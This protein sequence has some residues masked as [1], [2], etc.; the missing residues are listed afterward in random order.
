MLGFWL[1]GCFEDMESTTVF[2]LEDEFNKEL[3][4]SLDDEHLERFTKMEERIYLE[5]M[6]AFS[7][8]G[9]IFSLLIVLVIIKSKQLQSQYHYKYILHWCSLTIIYT[10]CLPIFARIISNKIPYKVIC[11]GIEIHILATVL[12][13]VLT[14][15]MTI[16]ALLSV[17]FPSASIKLRRR[18]HCVLLTLYISGI[19]LVVLVV[20][21]CIH[22]FTV[23][24]FLA[25][26][27]YGICLLTYISLMIF[28]AC[29]RRKSELLHLKPNM[30]FILAGVYMLCW[31]LKV[32]FAFMAGMAEAS[33]TQTRISVYIF[34][35]SL[36]NPAFNVIIL[37]CAD[38]LFGA[39]LIQ[40][41]KCRFGNAVEE[42][43]CIISDDAVEYDVKQE[44]LGSKSGMFSSP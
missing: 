31:F 23:A 11:I 12:N 2:S 29:K 5:L 21:I 42:E 39:A 17:H 18:T 25:P 30:V 44:V 9:G 13:F 37:C 27:T 32:F 1:Q 26:L 24:Q 16:D 22:R 33:V 8:L 4:E 6:F 14:L 43:G 3:N 36:L 15:L 10:V 34:L 19:F 20:T 28:H 40:I 35:V 41:C 38:G 7:I